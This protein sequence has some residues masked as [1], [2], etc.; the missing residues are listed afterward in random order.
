MVLLHGGPGMWDYLGPVAA[1]FDDIV[2]AHRY[3]QRGCGRSDGSGPYDVVT[4]IADLDAVRAAWGVDRWVVFGHSWGAS[5]ALLYAVAHPER[6]RAVIH[7]SGTGVDPAWHAEY[8]AERD[9]R[10]LAGRRGAAAELGDPGRATEVDAW[11]Y[12]DGFAVNE[13]ANRELGADANRAMENEA[14]AQRL[15]Q[16]DV[17]TL[18]IHGD[19]DPR[20]AKY[21]AKVAELIPG[22]ELLLLPGIGH[23]PRFEAPGPFNATVR[24]F[25]ARL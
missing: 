5:L 16:L 13:Q 14:F 15:A 7:V 3:D 6:T 22:A 23:Y 12:A 9:R 20:P 8:N 2:A 4:A 17:P 21:A 1:G 25:L 11:L 10:A 18:V 19:G 24:A